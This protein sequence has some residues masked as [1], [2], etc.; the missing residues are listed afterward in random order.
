MPIL[1]CKCDGGQPELS[2]VKGQK[3]P[4]L[5]ICILLVD[6]FPAE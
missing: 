4:R 3:L 1:A 5:F 2:N 6:L